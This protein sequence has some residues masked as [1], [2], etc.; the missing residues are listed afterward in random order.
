MRITCD[1]RIGSS[2]LAMEE[3][4]SPQRLRSLGRSGLPPSSDTIRRARGNGLAP[5]AAA[6]ESLL[7][8]VD[9]SF[10]LP[11]VAKKEFFA[12]HGATGTAKFVRS[13]ESR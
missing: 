8:A 12:K 4:T 13:R 7:R 3:G 5:E 11:D 6:Q 1:L 2:G 9:E 10:K